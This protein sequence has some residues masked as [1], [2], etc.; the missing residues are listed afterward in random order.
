M[1]GLV[2]DL[3]GGAPLQHLLPSQHPGIPVLVIA[4]IAE[5][6]VASRIVED[7]DPNEQLLLMWTRQLLVRII[8]VIHRSSHL[9]LLGV[10]VRYLVGL[11]RCL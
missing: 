1:A 8:V 11:L 4:G 7:V 5:S 6:E 2:V 3:A 9:I 10:P